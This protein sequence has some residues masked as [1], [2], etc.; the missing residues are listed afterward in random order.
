MLAD[1]DILLHL[2]PES[3]SFRTRW[4]LESDL[5]TLFHFSVQEQMNEVG[6]SK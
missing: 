1:S 6:G 4:K 5:H 3:W 2:D